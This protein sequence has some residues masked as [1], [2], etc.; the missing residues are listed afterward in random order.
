MNAIQKAIDDIK[1]IIPRTILETVFIKKELAW[2]NTPVNIDAQILIEVIRPR[3]LVDCNLVGGSEVLISLQGLSAE[4]TNQY[5]SVYRIPKERSQGRSIISVLNITYAD[6]YAADNVGMAT[7]CGV[8][9]MM[10]A[11]QGMLDSQGA[12]PLVSSASVQLIGENVV[13][14]RDTSMLPANVYLRCVIAHD[15]NMNHLQ[16]RSYKPFS[17]LCE[18]AVKA[19]IYNEYVIKMDQ[20]ELYGGQQLGRFKEIVDS[21]SDAEELYQEHLR[22]KMQKVLFMN[23]R[24]TYHRYMKGFIGGNH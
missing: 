8:S 9:S 7:G 23:D 15:D 3:V 4:R 18:F 20:G 21:Y 12:I 19:F 5:T 14:V 17:K 6:P 2:R 22:D 13:M 10:T 1:F 24:E 11:A 16:L